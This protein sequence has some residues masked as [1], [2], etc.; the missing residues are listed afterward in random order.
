[1]PEIPYTD[2]TAAESTVYAVMAALMHRL[3]TGQG[4]FIDVS[5]AQAA[6]ATIP[7]A[8]L[9]F[10]VNRRTEP[11]TGNEHPTMAPHGCYP[12]KGDDQW[13]AIAVAEDEQ[14]LALCRVLG[15]QEWPADS[16]FNDAQERLRRREELDRMVGTATKEWG[17]HDLMDRL[18][19]EGVAAGAVLDSKA[20]LFNDHLRERGFTR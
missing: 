8:L 3:R 12:C 17:A 18:Q 11:R 16:R 6:S 14:W 20:L 15:R 10:S 19:S 7:E 4:Q 1:M 9:D 5:Q 13:I 2:Y